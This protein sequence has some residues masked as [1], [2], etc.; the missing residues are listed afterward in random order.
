MRTTEQQQEASGKKAGPR[1]TVV[2][3]R[4]RIIAGY[5]RSLTKVVHV[6]IQRYA[7]FLDREAVIHRR[8]GVAGPK[9]SR[10]ARRQA[11][12]TM[13]RMLAEA[14]KQKLWHG[15]LVYGL[16][17]AQCTRQGLAVLHPGTGEE[18]TRLV[19]AP[20]F[21][22]QLADRYQG[23]RFYV[24]PEVATAGAEAV[25]QARRL[26][27]QGQA[28]EQFL[29]QGLNAELADAL[30]RYGQSRMPKLPG[31]RRTARYTPGYPIWPDL[32][33]LGKIFTLLRPE[34]IGVTLSEDYQM[35][36]EDSAAAL[37]MPE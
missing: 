21:A 2:C 35:T 12:E 26:G 30:A 25:E 14:H 16:F 36:P 37:V 29:L 6:E 10:A 5:A 24:A 33:E 9:T 34:R 18:L 22:R 19:F 17:A 1:T 27:E 3:N 13:E 31:W 4:P 7:L 15:S 23:D 11:D 8:W 28:Q 32:S 20:A